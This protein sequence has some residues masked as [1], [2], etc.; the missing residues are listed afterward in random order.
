VTPGSPELGVTRVDE[1]RLAEVQK[2]VQHKWNLAV[3]VR[4]HEGPL[5]FMELA[6]DVRLEDRSISE[7]MLRQTLERLHAGGAVRHVPIEK[8]V[9]AYELTPWGGRIASAIVQ[10]LADM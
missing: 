5:R 4:L 2:L 9:E 1:R 6:N 3:M 7:K 10:L 8:R